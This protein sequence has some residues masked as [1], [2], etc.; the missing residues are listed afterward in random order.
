M[1][2]DYS[3]AFQTPLQPVSP[4]QAPARPSQP[5][6]TETSS[7]AS[8]QLV[9]SR[10]DQPHIQTHQGA[11]IQ[12]LSLG[13][14]S[15]ELEEQL[16]SAVNLLLMSQSAPDLLPQ[17][18]Q[19]LKA[20][21]EVR[22]EL[23]NPT[24]E[25]L[26][27]EQDIFLQ[28]N[29][30]SD[31]TQIDLQLKE[32][33]DVFR[34]LGQNIPGKKT[35]QRIGNLSNLHQT[36]QNNDGQ[37]QG[38]LALEMAREQLQIQINLQGASNERVNQRNQVSSSL[39]MQDLLSAQDLII[40]KKG[41]KALSQL[42][43]ALKHRQ[44]YPELEPQ[45]LMTAAQ[46]AT[47][48]DK[49]AQA[50][51]YLSQ[52]STILTAPEHQTQIQ[53]NLLA[54]EIQQGLFSDIHQ[55]EKELT[56]VGIEEAVQQR[57]AQDL[58]LTHPAIEST[59]TPMTDLRSHQEYIHPESE[60]LSNKKQELHAQMA[61]LKARQEQ[62]FERIKNSNMPPEEKLTL[63]AQF[64]EQQG[65]L[66][67][68]LEVYKE[69]QQLLKQPPEP[70]EP[71]D[72]YRGPAIRSADG[73]FERIDE[74][75][76]LNMKIASNLLAQG[77][78]VEAHQSLWRAV[79]EGQGS[80]LMQ[81]QQQLLYAKAL[82]EAGVHQGANKAL[83]KVINRS[84]I[85]ISQGHH[86]TQHRNIQAEAYKMK[87]AYAYAEGERAQG[88]QL[89]KLALKAAKGNTDL[90]S[91]ILSQQGKALLDSGYSEDGFKVMNQVLKTGGQE[92]EALKTL[93]KD[94]LNNG[95][96][97]PIAAG[98]DR[99][100]IAAAQIALKASGSNELALSLGLAGGGA[101]V[102][103]F[104]APGVGTLIGAG[105]GTLADRIVGV[106]R[107]AEQIRQ[108]FN[109]GYE[110]VTTLENM[111]NLA[112]L[113]L[114]VVDIVPL[115]AMVNQSGKVLVREGQ[116]L[117][118]KEAGQLASEKGWQQILE[119]SSKEG[120]DSAQATAN[121]LN[122]TVRGQ[123]LLSY[124][125]TLGPGTTQASIALYQY[126][127]GTISQEEL[128]EQL[129]LAGAQ[130]VQ[131]LLSHVAVSV[132][133][134]GAHSLTLDLTKP[135]FMTTN[136]MQSVMESTN[137]TFQ[138]ASK[139]SNPKSLLSDSIQYAFNKNQPFID[140]S[141]QQSLNN[142]ADTH[143]AMPYVGDTFQLGVKQQE[144]YGEGASAHVLHWESGQAT[145][146]IEKSDGDIQQLT[147]AAEDLHTW[148]TEGQP[149]N[150]DFS[151]QIGNYIKYEGTMYEITG[152]S[153]DRQQILLAEAD[154]NGMIKSYDL[155]NQQ[156]EYFPEWRVL[157]DKQASGELAPGLVFESNIPTL[158]FKVNEIND[159]QVN[160]QFMQ[161]QTIPTQ[162]LEQ[163][164]NSQMATESK[165]IGT[166]TIETT[167]DGWGQIEI[168][169]D[170][171]KPHLNDIAYQIADLDQHNQSFQVG[172]S[173][174]WG[175]EL[176][177]IAHQLRNGDYLIANGEELARVSSKDIL[178][179]NEQST[180]KVPLSEAS[181]QHRSQN[182]S[183]EQTVTITQ[184]SFVKTYS[185]QETTPLLSFAD[186][187]AVF[188][189]RLNQADTRNY[190]EQIFTDA[191]QKEQVSKA[192]GDWATAYADNDTQAKLRKA[193]SHIINGGEPRNEYE[194][195]VEELYLSR[196][197]RWESLAEASGIKVPEKFELYRGAKG[198]EFVK[199]VV[200]AWNDPRSE[201]M[202]VPVL[203]LSSWSTDISVAED[204]AYMTKELVKPGE[205][206]T[207][208]NQSSSV[209]FRAEVPF[210]RTLGDRYVD[211]TGQYLDYEEEVIVALSAPNALAVPKDEVVVS[212]QGVRYT[213]AERHQLIQA[214]NA[215]HE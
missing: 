92:A 98:N 10:S 207:R 176:V 154:A 139:Q 23:E 211:P 142:F 169:P 208:P 136:H 14:N 135:V 183:D 198:E 117:L 194:S 177:T 185:E 182:I 88:D 52:A 110:N 76:E 118:A 108:T 200:A 151:N 22:Q 9:P 107:G 29:G 55:L 202:Q 47:A 158:Y 123:N 24:P 173:V 163:H 67:G 7:D 170:A 65:D 157:K 164:L 131:G 168:A 128:Q 39:A 33:Q 51:H 105:V 62:A 83:E 134:R 95:Q 140:A 210:E 104:I 26:E 111:F 96:F 80:P 133:M 115:G 165:K 58:E 87:A 215:A 68:A 19:A 71:T 59:R 114:D 213:Y 199:G 4:A 8:I 86:L 54:I 196:L 147:L 34:V 103:T 75:S 44:H 41:P 17:A 94:Y 148:L 93:F 127:Q 126:S 206:A 145:L 166:W 46:A 11:A 100:L 16:T 45:L 63:L 109:T 161:Q 186:L 175:E 13:F 122:Y 32:A 187:A 6:R 18:H 42:N 38:R 153:S 143:R 53:R 171:N 137:Q 78:A 159:Q 193:W 160:I 60:A 174:R 130:T 146:A 125:I 84:S 172:Q 201:M 181:E 21:G 35:I 190:D 5:P 178:W 167:Q 203:E 74:L 162:L 64:R 124:G 2:Q 192:L 27:L 112:G 120:L 85:K 12:S 113:A 36:Y 155:D 121:V 61:Q 56:T 91:S 144:L 188:K 189:T 15:Q 90:T 191:T 116:Q 72:Q 106:V 89:T 152:Q 48:S 119:A 141:T 184:D 37:S 1:I 156:M 77:K 180:H 205:E 43:Q 149:S 102:G 57:W 28:V 138:Y 50:V 150:R 69:H 214:W 49:P 197:D 129:A 25:L 212:F 79:K 3:G 31:F 97:D 40:G 132:A 30:Q 82:Q 81:N 101:V 195:N 66:E 209:L 70:K 99:D 179:N 204:F 73:F 20:Y